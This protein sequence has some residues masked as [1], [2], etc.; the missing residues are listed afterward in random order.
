M[1][2]SG[3]VST[4]VFNTRRVIDRAFGRCKLP[5]QGVTPEL[6]ETAR[7]NLFLILS[8]LVNLGSF[9]ADLERFDEA[10]EHLLR[11]HEVE[12]LDRLEEAEGFARRALAATDADDPE[13]ADREERLK[14]IRAADERDR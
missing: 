14:S 6:I 9:C 13:R 8:S 11:A 12:Q 10:E 5:P 1:P 4:T 3:T 2:T 7:D